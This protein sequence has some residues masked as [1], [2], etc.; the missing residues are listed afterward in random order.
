MADPFPLPLPEYETHARQFGHN[1][2]DH[3]HRLV[4]RFVNNYTN[5]VGCGFE[6]AGIKTQA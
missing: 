4:H 3:H 6:C 5:R 1:D 2:A